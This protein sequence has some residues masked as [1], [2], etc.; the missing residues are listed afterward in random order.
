MMNGN[1]LCF[2]F[3][4]WMDTKID[5]RCMS[6]YLLVL[7]TSLSVLTMIIIIDV[8]NIFPMHYDLVES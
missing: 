4:F 3:F 5:V 6:V 2:F 1:E 7:Q 8:S